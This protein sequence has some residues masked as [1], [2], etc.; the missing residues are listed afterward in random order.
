MP[1]AVAVRRIQSE[2]RRFAAHGWFLGQATSVL[3]LFV[4]EIVERGIRR[5][6]GK[7]FAAWRDRMAI[8]AAFIDHE[9][10]AEIDPLGSFRQPAKRG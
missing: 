3:F 1:Q 7:R 2:P 9:P 4:L 5:C 6:H 8:I 10:F